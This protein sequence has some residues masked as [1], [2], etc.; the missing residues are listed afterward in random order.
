VAK[1]GDTRTVA[2]KRRRTSPTTDKPD[3][4]YATLIVRWHKFAG[5]FNPEEAL[6]AKASSL[7]Y[8][9]TSRVSKK[10]GRTTLTVDTAA[11]FRLPGR[12]KKPSLLKPDEMKAATKI[13]RDAMR[14]PSRASRIAALVARLGAGEDVGGD[15]VDVVGDD[16]RAARA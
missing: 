9:I 7:D 3:S 2:G 8:V 12:G 6:R 4:G 10:T 15:L 13:L 5:E 16:G 14:D 11:S 1:P